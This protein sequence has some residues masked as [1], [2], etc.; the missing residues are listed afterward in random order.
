M[1]KLEAFS[2]R[3][4]NKSLIKEFKIFIPMG[5]RNGLFNSLNSIFSSERTFKPRSF[6]NFFIRESWNTPIF[7]IKRG[8]TLNRVMF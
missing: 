3:L 1:Q 6:V 5:N 2:K 7:E 4:V 8:I